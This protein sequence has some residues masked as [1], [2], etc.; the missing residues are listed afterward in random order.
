VTNPERG[1]VPF[2]KKALAVFSSLKLTIACLVLLMILVVACTLAQ[3]HLGTFG[4]VKVFIRSFWVTAQIPGLE[5]RVPVFPGGGAVGLVLLINLM[6]AQAARM[7]FSTRK[8]GLWVVHAG[9]ILLFT[10]EFVTGM[11]QVESNLTFE[12]GGTRAYSENPRTPEL[13]LIEEVGDKDRTYAIS[14]S[15]LRAGGVIEREDW[16]FTMLIKRVLVNSH[17]EKSVAGEKTSLPSIATRGA[18]KTTFAI[19]RAPVS[20]DDEVNQTSAFIELI[21]GDRSLGTWLVS[22]GIEDQQVFEYRGR[23]F[24]LALRPKRFPLAF[25]LMLKD[26][27]HETHPGTDIPSHFSSLVRL[28][29]PVKKEDREVLISMNDPLRYGGKTFYQASF[30]KEDTVSVLQVVENPGWLIPYLS[31]TL[32]ALGLIAHFL[33]RF[34]PAAALVVLLFAGAGGA[35]AASFDIRG[36]SELPV[37]HQGRLK[38]LDTVARSSLLAMQGKQAVRAGKRSLT[39]S[40]WLLDALAKPEAADAYAIFRVEDQEL[41]GLLGQT[42]RKPR[43]FSR[44]ELE[45]FLGELEQQF[46]RAGGI[47]P[48]ERTRFQRAVYQLGERVLLYHR[49]QKSLDVS[50][51]QEFLALPPAKELSP[52]AWAGFLQGLMSAFHGGQTHPAL[53]SY[54]RMLDAWRD[55]KPEDFN[56]ALSEYRGWLART[57]PKDARW[58]FYETLFNRIDPFL[59]SQVLYVAACLLVFTGWVRKSAGAERAALAVASAALALHT[60]GLFARMAIE[61][62]PPVTNLYSSAIFVGWIAAVLGVI[63]ERRYRGGLGALTAGAVGFSTLI[64]AHHLRL[65]G[66]TMEMMRAVLDSNFWLATHVVT[67]TVGYAGTFVAAFLAHV[68]IF[69]VLSGRLDEKK[70]AD[71]TR[72]VYAVI[73]FSLFFSFVGTVLGGIWADQSWGRFWGWDPKENGALMIVLWNA[74]ILHARWG[75]YIRDRGLMIAAVFGGIITSLSW[76]GVNMLGI[77]LHSY[78]FMDKAFVALATFVAT[79]LLVMAAGARRRA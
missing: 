7:E 68:R 35:E 19:E 12:E 75:G 9:L 58:A 4:A 33:I 78:G 67:I 64:I 20:K 18:G 63:L 54:K 37:V 27:R 28:K 31:C 29:D 30:G 76:F 24:R 47:E 34:K 42:Q 17:L 3:V 6:V 57:R 46:N 23:K 79:Q 70:A 41:L 65:S 69:G 16:P 59:W 25:S 14:E 52:N 39:P 72:Q 15:R 61:H 51:Q 56:A 40:E 11:F 38:P 8:A 55:G 21:D 22:L 44:Q 45:P 73:C 13:A 77:G 50:D 62:R 10:G 36:F 53:G 74:V 71:L 66:D 49:L 5:S 1:R 48:Q 32:V 26:F 2:W 43:S 60:A